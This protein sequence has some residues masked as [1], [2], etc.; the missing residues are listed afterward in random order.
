MATSTRFAD[1]SER[2]STISVFADFLCSIR[3]VAITVVVC[4]ILYTAVVWS[5]GALV[6]PGS[7]EGSLIR[8]ANGQ[9][10]GSSQIAQKFSRDEYFWPRPS[11]VDYNAAGTGGSNLSPLNPKI[12]ERAAA[13]IESLKPPSG[14]LVPADLVTASGSGMDPHITEPAALLQAP[15]VARSRGLAEE[16]VEQLIRQQ[17]LS[18]EGMGLVDSNGRIV[19]VLLLNLAM[20]RQFGNPR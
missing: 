11:A 10:I 3:M 20:D 17:S 13:I 15:R 4:C 6:V 8:D 2:G 16:R 14:A 19:N 7:A 12:T 1:E 18:P 9:V 5:V